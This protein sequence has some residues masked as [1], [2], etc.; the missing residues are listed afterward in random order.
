MVPYQKQ[1]KRAV[2]KWYWE[3]S[4]KFYDIESTHAKKYL[5]TVERTPQMSSVPQQK[6]P[7]RSSGPHVNHK[8]KTGT[9]ATHWYGGH[10]RLTVNEDNHK[11][12]KRL[13]SSSSNFLK[14]R[15]SPLAEGHFSDFAREVK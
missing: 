9:L 4:L 13:L 5:N 11:T 14:R 1:G 3:K 7:G 8:H 10:G 2:I 6:G 15:P 12:G